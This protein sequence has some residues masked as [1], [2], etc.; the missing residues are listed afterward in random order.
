MVS[1]GFLLVARRGIGW[2]IRRFMLKEYPFPGSGAAGRGS[3]IRTFVLLMAAMLMGAGSQARAATAVSE[4]DYQML[5]RL[6]YAEALGKARKMYARGDVAKVAA[7]EA[8]LKQ[9][10]QESGWT[11]DHYSEVND[12]LGEIWSNLR[13]VKN[14]DL[15]EA[16]FKSSLSE[17]DPATLATARAHF[18][19]QEG[20]RDSDRAE[21]QVR[22]EFEQARRGDAPTEARLQGTWVLD[23]DGTFDVMSELFPLPDR[24]KFKADLAA[25]IGSS[26]YTF[27]P[28]DQIVSRVTG[29]DGKER[30]DTGVYRIDGYKVFFRGPGA[31]REQSLDVGLR[32]GKLQMG[33]GFGVVVF[34]RQ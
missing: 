32:K 2:R 16:D 10:W 3:W 17:C 6:D 28:G 33:T 9:T 4:S 20:I 1:W 21:K 8:G 30:V 23:L 12:A 26:S 5:R 14:G 11:R 24:G 34:A 15:T 7:A 25:K 27:G 19:E 18:A 29:P 22:E 31:K 13:A